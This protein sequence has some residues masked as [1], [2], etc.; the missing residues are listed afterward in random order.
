MKID[1]AILKRF[2]KSWSFGKRLRK[3]TAIQVSNSHEQAIITNVERLA[4]RKTLRS[5]KYFDANKRK[6]II[7]TIAGIAK[8]KINQSFFVYCGSFIYVLMPNIDTQLLQNT[9]FNIYGCLQPFMN[10]R[11]IQVNCWFGCINCRLFKPNKKECLPKIFMQKLFFSN[12]LSSFCI[13]F[14]LF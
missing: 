10:W 2:N 12:Y 14:T 8:E 5:V 9:Q 1:R 3:R 11:W 4:K 6:L 7:T 13:S